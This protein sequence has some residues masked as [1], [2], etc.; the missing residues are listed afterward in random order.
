M[1]VHSLE[2]SVFTNKLTEP[3]KAESAFIFTFVRNPFQRIVSAYLNKVV[4]QSDEVWSSFAGRQSIDPKIPISFDEFVELLAGV[5]A[6]ESDPHW[7]PQHLNILYPFVQP[8]L[9]AD[10]EYLDS[11]M[12]K[13]LAHLLPNT[14]PKVFQARS[15]HTKARVEWRSYFADASTVGRT[16]QIYSADFEAFGYAPNLDADPA[17]MHS[18]RI[19]EHMHAG[20]G[21]YVAYTNSVGPV[22]FS[23]LNALETADETGALKN[24]IAF[25]RL[26]QPKLHHTD[27]ATLLQ[28]LNPD[29]LPSYLL[30]ALREKGYMA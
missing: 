26:R 15:H 21:R 1:K 8:N 10:L 11:E 22:R 25:Q 17:S 5:P 9:L 3:T 2:G 29:R 12:P 28:G 18:P 14:A 4:K 7:R 20:L 27:V 13:V 19:S 23:A 30:R 24:W 6:E 16:L